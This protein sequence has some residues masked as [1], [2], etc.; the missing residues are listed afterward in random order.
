VETSQVGVLVSYVNLKVAQGFWTWLDGRLFL[1]Q[2]WFEES[3]K[4]LRKRL[5][6]P[7][8]LCFKNLAWE[9]IEGVM[10]RPVV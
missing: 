1:P 9:L 5:G 4:T 8:S 7:E 2:G 6:M 10:G 3:H